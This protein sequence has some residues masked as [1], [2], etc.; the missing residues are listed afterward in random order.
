VNMDVVSPTHRSQDESA[1]LALLYLIASE[2]HTHLDLDVVL[3]RVLL[4]TASTMDTADGSLYIFDDL[5][6]ITHRL[7]ITG[8]QVQDKNDTAADVVVEKGLSG[9][10]IRHEQGAIVTNTTQDERWYSLGDE[11]PRSA[12]A[13]PLRTQTS[14]IGVLTLVHDQP[15]YF[16]DSDLA[17]LTVIADQAATAV[18]NARLY[19][20]EQRRRQLA[21][22]LAEV[23]QTISATLD[24]DRLFDVILEQLARVIH[25]D[26]S[27]ILLQ[28][29]NCL[30]VVAARGFDDPDAV[31]RLAFPNVSARAVPVLSAPSPFQDSALVRTLARVAELGQADRR[32]RSGQ[33][34]QRAGP[35][36]RAGVSSSRSGNGAE[37]SLLSRVMSERRAIVIDDVRQDSGWHETDHTR[38]VRGWIGAPLMTQEGVFG[39]LTVG[40]CQPCAY[41]QEDAQVVATFAHQAAIALANA[42]LVEQLQAAEARYARL[43]EDNTDMILIFDCEGRVLDA[44]RKACEL[45]CR[46]KTSLLGLDVEA[47]ETSLRTRF[48]ESLASWRAGQEVVFEVD[49]QVSPER[50]V[51][52]EFRTK[53]TDYSGAEGIQWS[54][55]DVSAR[56]ELEQ[57]RQDLTSMLVHDLRGPMGNLT[58][59]IKAIPRMMGELPSDSPLTQLIDV[60]LRSGQHM[61]DLVDSMLDVSRLEQGKVPLDRALVSVDDLLRAVEEQV[62]SLAEAK[63]TELSLST[64]PLSSPSDSFPPPGGCRQEEVQD[65]LP[66]LWVD[67]S[68]IRRVLVNLVEN[69]IKYSPSQGQVDVTTRRQGGFVVFSVTDQG[70][71][72]PPEYQRRIFDKFARVQ[73]EG[74]PAGVGLGLAFCRLAVEAHGGRIWVK[75]TLGQG[76]TFSFT[77]PITECPKGEVT[78]RDD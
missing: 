53:R 64:A 18:V 41:I 20:A 56:R 43:F 78:D 71:G 22:T 77:L 55:R 45:L 13:V 4:A 12:I 15:D 29:D 21:A 40:H 5:G 65:Q 61:R 26:S 34:G 19:Q 14:V 37:A 75:S 31:L 35:R 48:D 54:G 1:N 58:S 59:A 57:L 67:Q 70:Q 30:R 11:P 25:Y 47:L 62:F 52:V 66:K 68:M 74:A 60:A 50:V 49:L 10:V 46:D 36:R 76:S 8:W 63:Q 28:Q 38:H 33:D 44:N 16:A 17:I 73:N 72:I 6:N 39:V 27:A 32:G 23:S 51:P 2:L 9:W 3:H 7:I 69:A 24:L 42:R